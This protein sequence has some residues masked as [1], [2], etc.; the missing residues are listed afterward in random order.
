[1][2]YNQLFITKP[3]EH[4]INEIIKMFGLKDYNDDTQFTTLDMDKNNTIE[5]FK[6]NSKIFTIY[7]MPCKKK[8]FFDKLTNKKCI[9]IARQFLRT[10]GRDI[11]TN[12]KYIQ[13]T[14]YLIYKIISKD[15]KEKLKKEKKEKRMNI[16]TS[17]IIVTFD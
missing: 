15:E 11:I 6:R 3:F 17:E 8:I 9:T 12:E 13:G 16:T 14:K 5:N 2:V 1:M 4:D 7:Y 10:I